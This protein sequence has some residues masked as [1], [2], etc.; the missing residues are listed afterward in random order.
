VIEGYFK[1]PT[2]FAVTTF[3]LADEYVIVI[4][5]YRDTDLFA[6]RIRGARGRLREVQGGSQ[7]YRCVGGALRSRPVP[8]GHR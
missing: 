4:G 5:G 1:C 8:V 2:A 3:A 7:G 6:V